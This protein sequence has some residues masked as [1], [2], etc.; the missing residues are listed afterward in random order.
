MDVSAT[1]DW[2]S[3]HALVSLPGMKH[4]FAADHLATLDG[5]LRHNPRPARRS[6]RV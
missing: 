1:T 5:L 4:G 3:L 2:G 6:P